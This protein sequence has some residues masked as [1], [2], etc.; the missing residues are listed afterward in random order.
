ME[1]RKENICSCGADKNKIV[2]S[3]S[4]ASDVGM[5]SDLVARRL[6]AEGK[7]K[8]N[9][10]SVVGADIKKSIEK[11][12][13]KDVLVIDGCPVSC[14][15]RILENHNSKNYKHL[16]VTEQGFKKGKSPADTNNTQKVYD[17]AIKMSSK[18][19]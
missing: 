7:R 6:L 11:F 10:M 3:C 18:E 14:G 5:I 9:C 2:F 17:E 1:N 8:M 16:V 15:K 19:S 13:T 12:K 4:G